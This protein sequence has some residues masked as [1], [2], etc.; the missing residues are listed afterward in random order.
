MARTAPKLT[1]PKFDLESLFALQKAN[2]DSLTQAQHV[3][4]DAAQAILRLQHSWVQDVVKGFE[5]AG[6]VDTQKKPEAY[7]ADAKANA[8]KAMAIA[9]QGID[10][11]LKAQNEVAQILTK[12][13]TANMDEIKGFAAA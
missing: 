3:W 7:L 6:Q 10:L 1:F 9:K 11:G 13:A 8:E 2:L 5:G 12:R 4:V